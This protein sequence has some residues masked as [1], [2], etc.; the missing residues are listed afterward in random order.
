[1]LQSPK[2]T[3]KD[4]AFGRRL[5]RERKKA[6]FTQEKLAEKTNLSTTFIGLLEVGKRRA[7]IKSLQKIASALGMKVK[8]LINF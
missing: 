5:H 3:Q 2:I 1:M 8:D 6:G 7:S 4:L